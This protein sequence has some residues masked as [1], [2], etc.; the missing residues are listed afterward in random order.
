M[1]HYI[2]W[3]EIHIKLSTKHK[4]FCNCE[5]TQDFESTPPN[6]HACPTCTA[7]PGGLPTINPECIQTAIRLWHIFDSELNKNF[8]RDRK[9]YF[10]PDSP[11]GFQI[12]QFA[13]PIIKGGKVQFYT[14][15]FQTPQEIHIHEAHLENDTAKTITI[16]GTTFIDFNRSGGPLI[17][18]VT[19]PEFKSEDQVIEF[20]KELQRVVRWNDIGYA[21]LEKGQMRVDVNISTKQTDSQ[22][23]GTRVEIK[24]I[25][26][27]AAIRKAIQYEFQRQSALLSSGKSVDQETVRW[28]DPSGTTMTMRSKE[29]AHDYR[30]FSENDL[31][32]LNPTSIERD[33]KFETISGY[34]IIT[35]F[36]GFG[37]Q[38]EYIHGLL[39]NELLY[40]WFQHALKQAYEPKFIAKRLLWPIAS[41]LNEGWENNLKL[42]R[43]QFI[44]FLAIIQK[45]SINDNIAKQILEK[46]LES[47]ESL[48]E[49][50]ASFESNKVDMLQIQ[51]MI[52]Q[53]ITD[54]TKAVSDYQWWKTTT[55]AFFVGQLM[56]ATKG[57]IDPWQA[58]E[59]MEARLNR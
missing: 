11:T 5:N 37:F 55:I 43:D 16:D 47:W 13:E 31:P 18:I 22:I 46:I 19:K 15:N 33:K 26:S 25:N 35:Q 50:V 9:S 30:Y 27:F 2:I 6:T 24:N 7:Q 1:Y 49:V 20:L 3:L 32:L 8:K 45:Q 52:E 38:K 21:D 28:D 44:S 54:N 34:D 56:K 17:E 41:M 14:D 23:L 57:T 42:T 53:I 4:I 58:K 39:N 29:Q 48:E 40:N 36:L 51:E 59:L 10:Y 12:T